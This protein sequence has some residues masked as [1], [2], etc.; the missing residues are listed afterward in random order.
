MPSCHPRSTSAPPPN[1]GEYILNLENSTEFSDKQEAELIEEFRVSIDAQAEDLRQL[2]YEIYALQ[3]REGLLK[4]RKELT[5]RWER[6][7]ARR[8]ELNKKRTELQKSC[9]LLAGYGGFEPR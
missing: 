3:R 7:S 2:E 1:T 9:S 5:D 8:V 6:Q 4:T